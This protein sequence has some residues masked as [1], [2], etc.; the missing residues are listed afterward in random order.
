[1][2]ELMNQKKLEAL[3]SMLDEP[4][5]ISF[6][7]IREEI[8]TFGREA[9]PSLE[10]T[11]ENTFNPLMQERIMDILTGLRQE[12]LYQELLDW[13]LFGSSDL[14][15]GYLLVTRTQYP[16]LDEEKTVIEVEQMK[17]NIWLELNDNLTA[18]ENVKVMN[19]ILFEILKFEGNKINLNAPQNQYLNTLLENRKGSPLSLGMLYTILASKLKLPIMG[20]NLPQHYILAYLTDSGITS[21]TKDDVLFYI[22]PFNKGAVFTRRE[23]ELFLKQMKI[24]ADDSYFTPC[25]NIDSIERMINNLIYSYTQ[26]GYPEKI[27]DLQILLKALK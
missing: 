8:R 21:P 3:I 14:L 25:S 26:L 17:M 22:N 20:V 13:A 4:E 12:N 16:E 11:L 15:K 2:S 5:E 9:I 19:H 18:L 27:T 1:M 23:I 6:L 10:K 24:E 7:K